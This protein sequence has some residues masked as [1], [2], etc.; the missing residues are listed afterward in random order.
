MEL[1]YVKEEKEELEPLEG[2]SSGRRE[3]AAGLRKRAGGG[4]RCTPGRLCGTLR[5]VWSN[6]TATATLG[7]PSKVSVRSCC[8]P[9]RKSLA[10]NEEAW[11][12]TAALTWVNASCRRGPCDTDPGKNGFGQ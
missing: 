10:G 1:L 11:D 12:P 7:F 8:S 3:A 2:R 4:G 6:L 5:G 9:E